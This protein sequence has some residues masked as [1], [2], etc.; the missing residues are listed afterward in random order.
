MVEYTKGHVYAVEISGTLLVAG[1]DDL[2]RA[3]PV[4]HRLLSLDRLCSESD[5]KIERVYFELLGSGIV[6]NPC[7]LYGQRHAEFQSKGIQNLFQRYDY[8]ESRFQE[9]NRIIADNDETQLSKGV[10]KV[11]DSAK[12]PSTDHGYMKKAHVRL[13]PESQ[14]KTLVPLLLEVE[15]SQNRIFPY[16]ESVDFSDSP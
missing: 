3:V 2:L 10:E 12:G 4:S 1:T 14:R 11:F 7:D 5:S 16:L 13:L 6:P 8:M 15:K 9:I